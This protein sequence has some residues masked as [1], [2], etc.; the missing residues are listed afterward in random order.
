MLTVSGLTDE[1]YILTWGEQSREYSAEEL[2][3]GV[4]L[5]EKFPNNPFSAQFDRVDQAVAAKQMFETKQV[6]EIFHG[7]E[8]KADIEKAAADTEAQRKPLADAIRAAMVPV[9]HVIA[10]RSIKP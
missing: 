3:K 9:T 1:K 5:A 2:A 7:A 4:N 8:G 10:V 6:K